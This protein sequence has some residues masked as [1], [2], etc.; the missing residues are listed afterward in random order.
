MSSTYVVVADPTGRFREGE[1][2]DR[3]LM[4]SLASKGTVMLPIEPSLLQRSGAGGW[5]KRSWGQGVIPI[6]NR[7]FGSIVI[8]V[9]PSLQGE[10]HWKALVARET[11][12]EHEQEGSAPRGTLTLSCDSSQPG[13]SVA[14]GVGQVGGP[15][16]L[17]TLSSTA[18]ARLYN[19]WIVGGRLNL[20]IATGG[21]LGLSFYSVASGIRILWLAVSQAKV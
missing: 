1:L 16:Q 18:M 19:G 6:S 13:V 21:F 2:I 17:H 5:V 12:P 11:E 7:R 10:L 9:P 8:N 15:V 4:A 20:N 3:S 14:A